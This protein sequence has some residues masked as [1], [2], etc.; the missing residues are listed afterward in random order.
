MNEIETTLQIH[1]KFAEAGYLLT[2]YELYRRAFRMK[3]FYRCPA[4]DH[5]QLFY[6]SDVIGMTMEISC[7]NCAF[8]ASVPDYEI[9][10]VRSLDEITLRLAGAGIIYGKRDMC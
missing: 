4:C 3:H 2:D 9:M 7:K 8:H 1:A 5:P 6:W 10:S